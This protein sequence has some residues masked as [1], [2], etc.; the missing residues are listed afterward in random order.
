MKHVNSKSEMRILHAYK[1]ATKQNMHANKYCRPKLSE[2][3]V[4]VKT[5]KGSENNAH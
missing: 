3:L 5:N 1:F 4:L 2:L